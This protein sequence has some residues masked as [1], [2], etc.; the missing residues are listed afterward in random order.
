MKT[1]A[2]NIGVH[3][4]FELQLCLDVGSSNPTLC[5]RVGLLDHMVIPLL[6]SWETFILFSTVT[7]PTYIAINSMEVFPFLHPLQH[8]FVD[9]LMM[10][11]LIGVRWNLIVVL[12]GISQ[13]INNVEHLF[14]G[15]L[16][17]CISVLEKYHLGLLPIFWLGLSSCKSCLYILEIKP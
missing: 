5:P 13:M 1:A 6:V 16:A 3:V 17:I 14:M 8:L 7:S 12:I 15:P 2:V 9:C 4:S 10:A 11:I